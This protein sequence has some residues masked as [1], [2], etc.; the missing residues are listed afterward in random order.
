MGSGSPLLLQ[1][2]FHFKLPLGI[3]SFCRGQLSYKHACRAVLVTRFL[4]YLY[5]LFYFWLDYYDFIILVILISLFYIL[6]IL[7]DILMKVLTGYFVI[8]LVF[9]THL[10]NGDVAQNA[11]LA[12]RNLWVQSA[13]P[14]KFG[15]C[16]DL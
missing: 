12:C 14:H 8:A 10:G 6:P 13:A 9:K 15:G 3:A 4:P 16:T 11:Y 1:H 5:F 2:C 7:M